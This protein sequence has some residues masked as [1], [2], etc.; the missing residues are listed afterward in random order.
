MT[1]FD[2]R[3]HAKG[4]EEHLFVHGE[5]RRGTEK[6]WLLLIRERARRVAK[7]IFLSA[8]DAE[9][10]GEHLTAFD[11]RK[12]AENTKGVAG[13]LCAT[14]QPFADRSHFAPASRCWD[15]RPQA[16]DTRARRSYGAGTVDGSGL[17]VLWRRFGAEMAS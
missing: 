10:H 11:P 7:N 15:R 13:F 9:G 16:L 4:R 8:E 17:P 12:G 5:T 1:A 3:S 6:I 14:A 2:P